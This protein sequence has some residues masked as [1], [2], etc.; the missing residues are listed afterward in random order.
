MRFK[1]LLFLFFPVLVLAQNQPITVKINSIESKIINP[2]IERFLIHYQ[3]ENKTNHPVSFFLYPTTL[4]ANA[5]SSMTL[6][7]I[8]KL[9]VNNMF[10]ELDGPF[11]EKEYEGWEIIEEIED[12]TAEHSK[13]IIEE[14]KNKA[15]A[16]NQKIFEDYF[17]NGGKNTDYEWIYTNQKL[18]KSVITLQ[19]YE[20]KPFEIVTSWD[21]NRYFIQDDIEY[22]LNENENFTFEL[23]LDL[24]KALL[25]SQLTD[26]EFSKIEKDPN[27]IQGVFVSNK[28]KINF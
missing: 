12:K 1:Y 15:I 24:K 25:K 22:Y 13:I 3:I 2:K 18:L 19:P 17:K 14:I 5:A 6:Y 9:Y 8:Y 16:K 27:F 11:F 7:P 28:M 26:G 10:Q 21:Q 20:I 23:T 4:I